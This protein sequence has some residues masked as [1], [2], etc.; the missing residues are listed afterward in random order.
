ML[1]HSI[2]KKQIEQLEEEES[3]AY[4]RLVPLDRKG[5][6]PPTSVKDTNAYIREARD[7]KT[8][9]LDKYVERRGGTWRREKEIGGVR[10]SFHCFFSCSITLGHVPLAIQELDEHLGDFSFQT[11]RDITLVRKIHLDWMYLYSW[12]MCNNLPA[13]TV[14]NV[15]DW[16]VWTD[17]DS[18]NTGKLST[19]WYL[20]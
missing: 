17:G 13:C 7:V 3:N 15:C 19:D 20:L 6:Y 10:E 14:A 9:Q 1:L 16:N 2:Y 5:S 8:T 4:M 11:K 12:T 18:T